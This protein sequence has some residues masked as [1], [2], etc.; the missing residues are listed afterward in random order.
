M[1]ATQVYHFSE[2]MGMFRLGKVGQLFTL[3]LV[4]GSLSGFRLD[5]PQL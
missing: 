5:E 3:K 4:K 1:V 2:A